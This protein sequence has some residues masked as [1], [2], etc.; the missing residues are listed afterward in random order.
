MRAALVLVLLV[1]SIAHADSKERRAP[2]VCAPP[3]KSSPPATLIEVRWHSGQTRV[4]AKVFSTGMWTRA[5]TGYDNQTTTTGGR[6][7]SAT[8]DDIKADLKAAPWKITKAKVRCHE[9]SDQ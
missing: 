1:A 3:G 6:F 7:D 5:F 4:V 8:F 2:C 9:V